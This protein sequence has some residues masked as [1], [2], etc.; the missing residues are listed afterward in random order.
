LKSK[1]RIAAFGALKHPWDTRYSARGSTSVN[2]VDQND[3]QQN[4]TLGSELNI[5]LDRQNALVFE[6][7]KVV[8]H[9]NGAASTG[10]AVKYDYS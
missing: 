6:F 1:A 2:G 7:A 8:V 10:F 4:F 5:S 3:A 9:R